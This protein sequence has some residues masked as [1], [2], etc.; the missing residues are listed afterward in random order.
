[1]THTLEIDSR[2]VVSISSTSGTLPDSGVDYKTA[3][4]QE[5]NWRARD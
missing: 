2:H 1:M 5:R 4:F 3:V